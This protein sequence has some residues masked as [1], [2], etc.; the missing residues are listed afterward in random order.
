MTSS[1]PE[2]T[3]S[4]AEYRRQAAEDPNAFWRLK[5]G[6]HQNLLDEAIEQIDQLTVHNGVL[7][8][9]VRFQGERAEQARADYDAE[10]VT[11]GCDIFKRGE[12]RSVLANVTASRDEYAR[13]AKRH[14][15]E[16][17]RLRAENRSLKLEPSTTR[18]DEL[19]AE[20]NQ[21]I[22][23]NGKLTAGVE[24][25]AELHYPVTH[26]GT[27]VCNACTPL[28]VLTQTMAGRGRRGVEYPCATARALG[29]DTTS[30]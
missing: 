12:L 3:P 6:D 21:L 1:T 29:L 9:E 7:V 26:R 10:E 4:L 23:E 27:R 24:A 2:P 15:A 19:V 5:S 18:W 11:V 28:D 8:T 13:E 14:A 25:A 16:V 20:K 17:D 30:E 22:E